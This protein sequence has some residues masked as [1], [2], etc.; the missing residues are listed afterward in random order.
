MVKPRGPIGTGAISLMLWATQPRSSY[1]KRQFSMLPFPEADSELDVP[2][3]VV[4]VAGAVIPVAA[5]AGQEPDQ[6]KCEKMFWVSH[7]NIKYP[8]ITV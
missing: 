1:Y 7:H 6:E 4:P 2:P 8:L 3:V 5:L